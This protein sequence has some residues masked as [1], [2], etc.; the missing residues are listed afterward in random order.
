MITGVT[1]IEM[2]TKSY[3]RIWPRKTSLASISLTRYRNTCPI[4][5]SCTFKGWCA[6]CSRLRDGLDNTCYLHVGL[7]W[8]EFQP[9]CMLTWEYTPE[10][11]YLGGATENYFVFLVADMCTLWAWTENLP[12]KRWLWGWY[13]LY[14]NQLYIPGTIYIPHSL[15]QALSFNI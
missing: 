12:N 15:S 3:Y 1:C 14:G 5:G 2:T 6:V 10:P 4:G 8:L 13:L 7:F 9:T 11:W